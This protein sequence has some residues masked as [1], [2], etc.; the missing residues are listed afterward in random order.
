MCLAHL[1]AG[2]RVEPQSLDHQRI[3]ERLDALVRTEP[4]HVLG[5]D[6]DH[7]EAGRARR[8]HARRG[9][10]ERDGRLGLDVE[11]LD[12]AQRPG[13]RRCLGRSRYRERLQPR[14]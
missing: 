7:V 12:G 14:V 8:R 5:A 9:V 10:L 11:Q 13:G 4:P 6:H 1:P 2:T 3:F